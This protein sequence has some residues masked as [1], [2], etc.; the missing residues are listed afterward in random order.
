MNE[1]DEFKPHIVDYTNF[2]NPTPKMS[3]E[4]QDK[5]WKKLA[6]IAN[7]KNITILTAKSPIQES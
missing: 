1:K 3:Y 7:S 2:I 4:K 5:I 6:E